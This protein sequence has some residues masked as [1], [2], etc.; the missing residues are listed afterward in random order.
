MNSMISDIIVCGAGYHQFLGADAKDNKNPFAKN[1]YGAYRRYSLH[2]VVSGQ[3]EYTIKGK[4]YYL[5]KGHMFALFPQDSSVYFPNKR[6]PWKYYW[7]DFIGVKSEQLLSQIGFTPDSPILDSGDSYKVLEK[8]FLSNITTCQNN[9]KIADVHAVSTLLQIYCELVKKKTP[10]LQPDK[11]TDGYAKKAMNYIQKNYP[12]PNLNLKLVAAQLNI[13]EAY[14]SRLFR[15]DL[16][17]NFVDYLTKVRILAA[18]SLIDE[19]NKVV[20]EIATAVGFS[21]PY[22][23]SKVFK[24]Y[25]GISPR[26]QIRLNQETAETQSEKQTETEE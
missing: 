16:N 14:L 18:V 20:G 12:N 26:D 8:L 23:F 25:N 6:Y 13:N 2:L 11:K 4:T 10:V 9:P 21:D 7:I 19:G 5:K 3:G 1:E 24:K 22:Y 17:I 15:A